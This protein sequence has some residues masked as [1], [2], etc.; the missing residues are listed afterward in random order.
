MV[1]QFWG[2]TLAGAS[3][4]AL[5][6]SAAGAQA[7]TATDDAAGDIIVTA[8]RR[9]ESINQIPVSISASTGDQLQSLG[10]NDVAG[11]QKIVPGFSFALGNYGAP[12]YSIRGIGFNDNSLA[13]KPAVALSIDEVP[14]PFPVMAQG[15]TLDLDRVEVLKGPQGTLYG[16]NATGGAVNYISAKPTD[17]ASMG[18]NID[19]GRF[20]ALN[21]ST[22]ISGP[23][24]DTLRAR[25]AVGVDRADEWQKS[26]TRDDSLGEQELYKGRFLL[27]WEPSADFRATFS[28]NGFIDKSDT[29][30]AQV[31]AITPL[32][33][34]PVHIPQGLLDYPL[35]PR[36]NRAADWD[37]AR[38]YAQ[39]NHMYQLALRL[40]YDLSEAIRLTSISSYANYHLDRPND[41]DGTSYEDYYTVARGSARVLSQELRLSGDHDGRIRWIVGGNYERDRVNQ[42]DYFYVRDNGNAYALEAFGGAYFDGYNDSRQRLTTLAAFGNLDVDLGDAITLHGGIRYTR[43]KISHAGCTGDGGTGDLSFLFSNFSNY[44]RSLSGLAPLPQPADGVCV[45]LGP[46]PEFVPGAIAGRLTQ[47][48]VSW[49]AGVD[50]KP[51]PGILAYV[52]VSKGYKSGS[53]P[54]LAASTAEQYAPVSQESV[55]AYEAGIKA[56]LGIAQLNGAVFYYDYRDKQLLGRVIVPV[57]GPLTSLVNIPKSSI[58][59]AEL[60]LT[61]RPVDG[62]TL[63]GGGTYIDSK[64]KGGFTNYDPFG[65]VRNFGGDPFPLT[66]KWQ[67]SGDVQYEFPVSDDL[68]AFAGA[69]ASY[70]G[71]TNGGLGEIDL[72]RIDDYVLIDLRAGVKSA[73]DKWRFSIWGRNITDKYYWTNADHSGN[74]TI[75]LAGRPATYGASLAFRY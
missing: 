61:L 4:I 18:F 17:E 42:R 15:A 48:N 19:F 37:A 21:V 44:L 57:F 7:Q 25:L 43:A 75:R 68:K 53:F 66:P 49:R 55:L 56:R 3:F 47:D 41:I 59:G 63:T 8:Q 45:T 71:K 35:A 36:N 30:A 22:F 14:L 16:Q 1:S 46:G 40:E 73:D 65:A 9:S 70:Q 2:R 58:T 32:V 67:A 51:A 12:I 72:L 28:A 38:P 50:W 5:V 11:L 26:Y 64:I 33:E 31:I 10:V 54:N 6:A 29:M 69:N 24:S 34:P 23:L 52:N 20:N 13:A 74:T 60:Q 27:E 39:D 62:L